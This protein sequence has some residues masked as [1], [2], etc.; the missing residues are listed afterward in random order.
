MITSHFIFILHLF[1][2][3]SAK[4]GGVQISSRSFFKKLG[5]LVGRFQ[6]SCSLLLLVLVVSSWGWAS[7]SIVSTGKLNQTHQILDSSRQAWQFHI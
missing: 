1:S 5:Q 6:P 2:T 7:N 3:E 4:F